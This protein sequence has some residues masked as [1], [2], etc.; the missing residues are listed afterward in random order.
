MIYYHELSS[1]RSNL[2][3]CT[4][5]NAKATHKLVQRYLY[6]EMELMD[7]KYWNNQ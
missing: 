3:G 2:P 6:N 7:D 1:S 5:A 4:N